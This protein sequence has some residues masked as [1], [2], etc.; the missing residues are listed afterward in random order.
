MIETREVDLDQGRI[1]VIDMDLNRVT[2]LVTD[3]LPLDLNQ[4]INLGRDILDQEEDQGIDIKLGHL[5]HL[6][7]F[8]DESQLGIDT[9][10]RLE[11]DILVIFQDHLLDMAK[12]LEIFPEKV[13]EDPIL[14]RGIQIQT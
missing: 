14:E 2:T 7:H 6:L 3:I 5:G 4:E 10:L 1:L 11:R 13:R 12:I 9:D 8:T